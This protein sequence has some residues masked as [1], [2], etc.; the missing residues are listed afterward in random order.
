[1]RGNEW[2]VYAVEGIDAPEVCY[3]SAEEEAVLEPANESYASFVD[4]YKA[5]IPPEA[6]VLTHDN[7]WHI[8]MLLPA[9]LEQKTRLP[10]EG[11]L[12]CRN[13]TSLKAIYIFLLRG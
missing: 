1:M 6:L 5:A 4:A 11:Q 2:R 10:G 9:L 13:T 8:K 12:V 3:V 7:A